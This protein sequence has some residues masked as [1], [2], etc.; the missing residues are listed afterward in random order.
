[1]TAHLG[2]AATAFVDGQL[3]HRQRDEVI[4]HLLHCPGCKDE[5]D[6]LRALKGSLRAGGPDIPLDL[7]LRLLA[8]V[9][10]LPV[11]QQRRSARQHRRVRRTAVGGALVA[12]GIGG[13][14]GLAGPPPAGPAPRVDP[15]STRFVMDHAA[16]AGE[17]PFTEPEVVTISAVSSGSGR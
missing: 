13:S 16:T 12:L 17:V 11:P 14:L 2:P 1:M 10:Q 6:G 3:D 15:T 5:V 4:A 8:A 9:P 7:S